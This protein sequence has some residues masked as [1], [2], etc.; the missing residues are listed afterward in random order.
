MHLFFS[1]PVWASKI[2]NFKN[3]NDDLIKYIDKLKSNDP[4]GKRVSNVKGWH[5]KDFDLTDE[6]PKNFISAASKN[7]NKTFNDMSW[8]LENQIVKI[9]NIWTIVNE[10]GAF[11]ERHQHGNS[12]LSAAYYVKAPKDCGEIVFYDPRPAPIYSYPKAISSNLLNA[13]VN[14][15]SPKEGGLILFPSYVDH[16]VNENLSIKERIVISFNI[17]IQA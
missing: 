7:I 10:K 14:G 1:T 4:G 5:S 17:T 12:D 8:D 11:N 9:T 13:Q 3:I 2:E 15:I 6:T 16:S